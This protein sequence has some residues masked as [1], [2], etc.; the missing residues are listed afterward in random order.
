MRRLF[1]A[2]AVFGVALTAVATFVDVNGNKNIMVDE[3]GY[4]TAQTPYKPLKITVQSGTMTNIDLGSAY[5]GPKR[6]GAAIYDIGDGVWH[7][8]TGKTITVTGNYI[9]FAGNWLGTNDNYAQMFN[10]TFTSNYGIYSSMSG[11]LKYKPVNAGAYNRMFYTDTGIVAIDDNPL[12]LLT[13]TPGANMF[14]D[15]FSGVNNMTSTIPAGLFDTRGITGTVTDCASMFSGVFNAVPANGTLPDGF[16]YMS[17]MSGVPALTMCTTAFRNMS[18][19]T[20]VL[21]EGFLDTRG[22]SGSA[23][24]TN[25]FYQVCYDMRG[26]TVLPTGFLD[27]SGLT[28]TPGTQMVASACYNMRSVTNAYVFNLGS[29]IAFD[30]TNVFQLNAAWRDMPSWGGQVKWGTNVLVEAIPIPNADINT[31]ANST[32]MPNYATINANWK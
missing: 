2:L 16:G 21:P 8:Y 10:A 4:W 19:V 17:G 24:E 28:G 7:T 27:L 9:Q 6:S 31:F 5:T 12:P 20:G 13:G 30:S 22:L 3:W 1:I 14:R 26:V 23:S 25:I 32:N 29:G 11:A 18:N 15:T